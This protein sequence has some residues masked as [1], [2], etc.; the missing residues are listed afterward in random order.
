MSSEV[1]A[2][3]LVPA[4]DQSAELPAHRVGSDLPFYAILIV[5]G[6]TYVAMLAGMLV[7]DVAYMI[8]ADSGDQIPLPAA[9]AWVRPILRPFLPIVAALSKPEVQFSIKLT[10]VSCFYSAILSVLVAV[11]LGYA[12]TRFPFRGGH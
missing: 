10:L 4:A 11:P 12:I 9:V 2:T 7:A 5:V 1:A 8:A 6:G 3:P